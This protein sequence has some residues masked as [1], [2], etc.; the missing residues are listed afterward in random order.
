[1]FNDPTAASACRPHA[2][3]DALMWLVGAWFGAAL[4]IGAAAAQSCDGAEVEIG[5]GERQCFKPGAGRSFRDCPDCPEMVIVPAGSFTMGAPTAEEVAIERE[6][7]VRVTISQPFAVGRFAVTRGEFAAFIAATDHKIDGDCYRLAGTRWKREAGADW[8]SP[9]FAQN[10]RHPVVCVS[11]HDARAYAAWL[12]AL[13]GRSY[14]LL[15]ETEREYVTRAGST[16]PFWWG[17]RISTDLA[18]YDGTIAYG[19]GAQGEWRNG[20]VS[21]DSFSANGWGLYNVHGNVWD[22][23]DDC[24]NAKN[25]GNPADGTPRY[26]GDC[27][28][29]V[30]RGASW[31]NAP[32][33]L[34]SARRERNPADYRSGIIGFRVARTLTTR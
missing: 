31:N 11:W 25:A 16:T 28:L 26:G 30:Q 9:G 3:A 2:L 15:S 20:T 1:M 5:A 23:V 21:V 17:A 14:R 34:R 18:N 32:H 24:W 13:T 12:S 19:S 10:D 4:S 22:W 33:T 6:D 7:E 29:R 8:R 27:G